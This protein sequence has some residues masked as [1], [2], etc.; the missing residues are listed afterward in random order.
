[1]LRATKIEHGATIDLPGGKVGYGED[2]FSALRR[3]VLEETGLNITPICPVRVWSFV[4]GASKFYF[5][6][7]VACTSNS[8]QVSLSQE[9]IAFEWL[10]RHELPTEWPEC[11]ELRAVL[12]MVTLSVPKI[13]GTSSS[14]L[15][16]A[17]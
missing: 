11:E 10:A 6:I 2:P 9:H 16:H 1:M 4:E 7:T 5:G 14:Q 17:V 3:E 8:M 15:P 13:S 12:D